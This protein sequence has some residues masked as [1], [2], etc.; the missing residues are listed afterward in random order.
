MDTYERRRISEK[1][2][3][4]EWRIE[5]S[6]AKAKKTYGTLGWREVK[7]PCLN[8]DCCAIFILYYIYIIMNMKD[9]TPFLDIASKVVCV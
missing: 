8:L 5:T 3:D 9:Y 2:E 7:K 6:C 4:L 1:L